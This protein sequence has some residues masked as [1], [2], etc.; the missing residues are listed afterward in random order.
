MPREGV[1]FH[2]FNEPAELKAAEPDLCCQ[3][4][5]M[6]RGP[7]EVTATT[8]RMGSMTLAMGRVSPCLSFLRIAADRAVLQLPC[9]RGEGVVL[10]T[11][12]CRP[13]LAGAYAAGSEL[14][15]AT[16]KPSSFA[17]LILPS[18][19]VEELLEPPAG[20]KLLQRGSCTLLQTRSAHWK[21]TERI[22]RGARATADSVPGT[23][24]AEQP[25]HALRD[26]LLRA[27]HDL[28]SPEPE[29]EI[30]TPRVT[31]ARRRIVVKADEYLRAHLDRPI[32]TEELCE[33][34]AVSASGL[35]EAF[36]T[37]FAVS[38]HRF[39]KLR[40]LSMVRTALRSREGLAPLV[41]SVALSHGFW[42][43]GQF[44]HD[45]RE[46]FG[47]MPSETLARTRG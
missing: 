10:N 9:G 28:V 3:A 8:I 47:E 34:L 36:R 11:V 39:L 22:L 2:R 13:G 45:Y 6:G 32:Y 19:A 41:K 38:P 7:F 23:F 26:D 43:L 46:T 15:Y 18:G 12:A 31:R 42:H 37:V 21:R 20:S 17:A 14:L 5:P 44:A 30:R 16:R 25:R 40:R 33:A 24:D 35:S 4:I 29:A 27:A 1:E